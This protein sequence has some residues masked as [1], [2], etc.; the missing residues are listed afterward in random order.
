MAEQKDLFTR[1]KKMFSTDVIVR[2]VGGKNLKIIDTDE[3]QYAT[4]RNSL[5]DRFNRLRSSTYNLHNRDMSM[6]YQASRLE[7]FRD[8]DCVG[9]DTIIPLPDGTYPTIKELTEKY[10]DRPQERF[11]VFSYD[12]ETDTI[13]LGNAYHPRKKN[14]GTRKCWKVI[15][16]DK[17]FIIGSAGHPFLMRDGEYKKLEELVVGESVMP[18]YQ[19]DFYGEGYRSIYNFSKGWQSEHK[20]VAEQFQRDLLNNE[21]VHH[22]DFNKTNNLPDNLVIMEDSAH[23]S[24]HAKLNNEKIWGPQNREKQLRAVIEGNKKRKPHKWNRKRKGEKN[25]FYGKKH[26]DISNEKRSASLIET[27]TSR[28]QNNEVNPNYREDLTLGLF[29]QKASDYYKTNG[30]LTSWGLVKE[31]GCDYSV[32]QNRLKSSGYDWNNFKHEVVSMLNH[33]IASIEYVGEMEVYD[34]TVEKYQNFATDSVF[35]H[36]TMDMDPIIASALDIYSDEC[37]VPSEFGQVLTIRSKNENIKKILN[38]LFYDI[39]NVEF[40]MWSWTRNMCKYGDFF[41]RLEIS[42]EYGVY[43]VHPI[44]PY[45]L[46]R[47]EGSDPKNLNYVKYQHDGAGG[48]MEYENFEIAHFRLLSDSNFLPYGKCLTA[49]NYIETEYGTARITDIEIGQKVWTFNT[50][51]KKFELSEV[52]H[53]VSSGVKEIIKISTQHNQIECSKNHPVLVFKDNNLVY[54]QAEEL[55][56]KDLLVLSTNSYKNSKVV[57][58]NKELITEQNHNGWK[59]NIDLL[60]DI[61]DE[62]FV[63]FFGFMIGDGWINKEV[64]RVNFAAGIYEDLNKKYS[65][66][67]AEYTGKDVKIINARHNSGE[68][69]YVDSKLFAEFMRIN[70]FIGNS[71]EKEF[72]LGCMS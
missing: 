30:K 1:L 46:T 51:H 21:V 48:G 33:K 10:K 3:I 55:S 7:L 2:A 44:S 43:M 19:K 27:F 60:P 37:L 38:N 68:Q 59:N 42:P 67:L 15:F 17:K 5:R 69:R 52:T 16:D 18:F 32:L 9:E 14:G 4:D 63:Q 20:I 13:K 62:K 29:K 26:T 8:Y 39:L 23:R 70:G 47:V 41:L 24:Y 11:H 35:V 71:Y 53:K 72:R 34:V 36:N 56:L 12:H 31:I 49:N 40:N 66:I 54:K 57:K 25:P 64:N 50:E 61:A 65:D 45:E 22:R 58:L 28:Y 6:A